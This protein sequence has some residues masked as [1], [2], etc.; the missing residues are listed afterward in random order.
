LAFGL[1][2][3]S[4]PCS[5]HVRRA[6]RRSDPPVV[7]SGFKID[8]FFTSTSLST[9]PRFSLASSTFSD[10][11]SAVFFRKYIK[12]FFI[13]TKLF[14]TIRHYDER[15][16]R[17]EACAGGASHHRVLGQDENDYDNDDKFDFVKHI[18][19]IDSSFDELEIIEAKSIAT[20]AAVAAANACLRFLCARGAFT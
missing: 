3:M 13:R 1:T 16:R 10:R 11:L 19:Q 15:Q 6:P 17:F 4:A 5:A 20:A 14:C 8:R 18:D 7:C 12:I 9:T 2:E